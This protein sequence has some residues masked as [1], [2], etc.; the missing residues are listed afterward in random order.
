MEIQ[1]PNNCIFY[2]RHENMNKTCKNEK[3]CKIYHDEICEEYKEN[4]NS[5][6]NNNFGCNSNKR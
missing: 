3:M 6:T 5:D 4:E 2:N 1:I